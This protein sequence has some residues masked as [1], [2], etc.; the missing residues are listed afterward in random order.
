M[1]AE[2]AGRPFE[3]RKALGE[4]CGKAAK[5]LD[6]FKSRG[7][8]IVSPGT[9]DHL[10]SAE[11]CKRASSKEKKR[12]RRERTVRSSI[13]RDEKHLARFGGRGRHYDGKAVERRQVFESSRRSQLRVAKV[14]HGTPQFDRAQG[15]EARVR[16][17]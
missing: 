5:R 3:K 7:C 4:A 16:R 13:A 6:R 1:V 2:S 14:A 11:H 17:W 10:P 8:H 15:R 12:D 9:H